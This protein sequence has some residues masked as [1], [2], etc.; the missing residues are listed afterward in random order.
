MLS[1]SMEDEKFLTSYINAFT[2]VFRAAPASVAKAV[3]GPSGILLMVDGHP[4]HD[5]AATGAGTGAEAGVSIS[6]SGSKGRKAS[7]RDSPL[8]QHDGADHHSLGGG[9]DGEL[10]IFCISA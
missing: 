6:G 10:R 2:A 1:S 7:T 8:R 3:G 4:V 9:S 5:G